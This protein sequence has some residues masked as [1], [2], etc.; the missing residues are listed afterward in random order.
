M[1]GANFLEYKDM[2][3]LNKIFTGKNTDFGADWY[4]DIGYQLMIMML[5]FVSSPFV[6]LTS[7]WIILWI[8]RSIK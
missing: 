7:E 4:P 2:K 5:L 6:S 8:S 1:I 3:W